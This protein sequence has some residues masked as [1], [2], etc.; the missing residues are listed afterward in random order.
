[1]KSKNWILSLTLIFIVLVLAYVYASIEW[2]E[3]TIETGLSRVAIEQP[4]LAASKLLKSREKALIQLT[5]PVELIVDSKIKLAQSNSLILDEASFK[6]YPQLDSKVLNWVSQGGHLVLTLSRR[7]DMLKS[8]TQ[9]FYQNTGIKVKEAD[10]VYPNIHITSKAEANAQIKYGDEFAK[11]YLPF[12]H[13]VEDCVGEEIKLINKKT[14]DDTAKNDEKTA[15]NNEASQTPTLICEIGFGEGYIT[16]I[17]SIQSISNMALRQL[18]HGIFLLWLIGK[19]DKLYYLPSLVAPNWLA[20]LWHWSWIF[21][22]LLGMSLIFLVWHLAVRDGNPIT[23]IVSKRTPFASH[24]E[25]T[26]F[27]MFNQQHS[28]VLKKALLKDITRKIEVKIPAFA[29]MTIDNQCAS[30]SKITEFSEE[31]IRYLLDSD[32]PTSTNDKIKFISSLKA[33]RNSL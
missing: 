33:L 25:A 30:L 10:D 28:D 7:H 9:N 24:I 23:P 15:E 20:E 27:Y 6:E 26:G 19:N 8:A 18:D 22:L 14:D 4:L 17:P 21:V 11:I 2:E 32:I 5:S 1:M 3:K 13:T 16:V 12:N 31:E 29:A